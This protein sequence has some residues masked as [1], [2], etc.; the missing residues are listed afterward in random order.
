MVAVNR[1][2]EEEVGPLAEGFAFEGGLLVT[3]ETAVAG[4]LLGEL[5]GVGLFAGGLLAGV[6]LAGGLLAAGELLAG[7]L[8]AAGELL[9]GG[10]FAAGAGVGV[11]L[12]S[13]WAGTSVVVVVA[14]RVTP[15][16]ESVVVTVSVGAAAG[17]AVAPA[18]GSQLDTMVPPSSAW[19]TGSVSR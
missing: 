12:D 2:P 3:G 1:G 5:L 9:A 13:A 15:A 11:G 4:E 8:L 10:L 14:L 18:W 7:G 6:L 16:T 19:T 17:T